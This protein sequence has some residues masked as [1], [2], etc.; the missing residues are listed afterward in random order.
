MKFHTKYFVHT[1]TPPLSS[2]F[3]DL[4]SFR[5]V[6]SQQIGTGGATIGQSEV[7]TVSIPS[8]TMLAPLNHAIVMYEDSG[9]GAG[10]GGGGGCPVIN[11]STDS[12]EVGEDATTGKGGVEGAE[13]A[14]SGPGGGGGFFFSDGG[15]GTDFAAALRIRVGEGNRDWALTPVS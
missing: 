11:G 14:G 13:G 12:E 5:F 7:N 6:T 15:Q 1:I 4:N 8:D 3:F 10:A 2:P 9:G